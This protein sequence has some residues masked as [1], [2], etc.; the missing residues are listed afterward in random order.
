MI[1]PIIKKQLEEL[2]PLG[3]PDIDDSTYEIVIPKQVKYVLVNFKE[4]HQ[5]VIDL[6]DSIV[7]PPQDSSLHANWN[8][9]VVPKDARMQVV[10]QQVM[11]KMLKISGFGLDGEMQTGNIWC[12]WVPQQ[13]IKVV[14]EI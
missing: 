13:S 14:K 3:I 6:A 10:V 1:N 5:Y 2:K 12:G 9:N 4:G 11:G 7:N 8:N